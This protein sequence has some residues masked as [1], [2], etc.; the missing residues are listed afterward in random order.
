M[1]WA[2]TRWGLVCQAIADRFVVA[3]PQFSIG[4]GPDPDDL[5]D[6][7]HRVTF[8]VMDGTVADSGSGG[9]DETYHTFDE[10]LPVRV[11]I[12]VPTDIDTAT[13]YDKSPLLAEAAWDRLLFEIDASRESPS[14]MVPR[15]V[16][17]R[18]GRIAEA[19]TTIIAMCEVSVEHFR[20][21]AAM[22]S[23]E[24]ITLGLSVLNPDGNGGVIGETI[25]VIGA[26]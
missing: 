3:Y 17:R 19:G 4:I 1:T 8:T 7:G 5:A 16:A 9:N 20:P 15:S 22:V 11:R 24:S 10:S 25:D 13:N 14:Y 2:L 6:M 12:H 21:I 26:P 23:A 18:G